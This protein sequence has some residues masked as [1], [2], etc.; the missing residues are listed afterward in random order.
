LLNDRIGFDFSFFDFHFEL[1][2]K[3]RLKKRDPDRIPDREKNGPERANRHAAGLHK[4]FIGNRGT[5]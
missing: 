5:T 1:I 3:A 2:F 4:M